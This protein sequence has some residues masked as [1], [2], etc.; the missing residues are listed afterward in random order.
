MSTH[1]WFAILAVWLVLTG[2]YSV[3]AEAQ[4]Q[5]ASTRGSVKARPRFFNPFD[6]SRSRLTMNPFGFF[7]VT[8][9]ADFPFAIQSASPSAPNAVT[10]FQATIVAPVQAVSSAP[11]AAAPSSA[12][13]VRETGALQPLSASIVSA[14]A[15]A[16]EDES[17]A[18]GGSAVRPPYRPPVRS[19]FRPPPRPPF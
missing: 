9:P 8:D 15:T 6:V 17:M 14:D 13:G 5:P 18:G 10:R 11:G 16:S 19:P 4:P 7:S 12:S 3:A 1:R 2:V